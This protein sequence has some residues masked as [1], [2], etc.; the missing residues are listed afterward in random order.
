MIRATASVSAA[1][2]AVVRVRMIPVI[3]VTVVVS[4]VVVVHCRR[5]SFAIA[6]HSSTTPSTGSRSVSAL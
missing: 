6:E 1:E 5:H 2:V 4:I 3:V